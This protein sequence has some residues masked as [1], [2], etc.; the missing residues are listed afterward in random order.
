[1]RR[2]E[3]L[4]EEDCRDEFRRIVERRLGRFDLEELEEGDEVNRVLKE[5]MYRVCGLR[6]KGRR[7]KGTALWNEV[8][9]VVEEKRKAYRKWLSSRRNEELKAQKGRK[10]E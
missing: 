9:R 6:R 4:Q 10:S 2:V 8:K 5:E 7:V 1:M 3:R